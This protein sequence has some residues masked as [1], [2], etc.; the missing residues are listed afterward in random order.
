MKIVTRF[1]Y[2]ASGAGARLSC[3]H[4]IAAS[5]RR[6]MLL[7]S[8]LAVADKALSHF[9]SIIRHPPSAHQHGGKQHSCFGDLY[10]RPGGI[11][12]G[13]AEALQHE[14]TQHQE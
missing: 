10:Q 9:F 2:T 14:S 6:F 7:R 4:G 13:A 8:G 1:F 11:P 12:G 5:L 3:A